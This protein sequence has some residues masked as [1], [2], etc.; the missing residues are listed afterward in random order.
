THAAYEYD[1][2]GRPLRPSG[3]AADPNPFRL[4]TKYHDRDTQRLYH[5]E[6]YYPP[7]PGR[8]LG[9]DPLRDPGGLHLQAHTG[10][11]P[12]NTINALGMI[13]FVWAG[14]GGG[15]SYSG[16]WSGG[17]S[18]GFSIGL[19]G[20][21]GYYRPGGS[22]GSVGRGYPLEGWSSRDIAHVQQMA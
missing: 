1:P 8:F 17:A 15:F 19:G 2:P 3:P 21:G 5:N 10:N 14:G 4:A 7:E 20:L 6:R 9:L 11:N 13:S 18:G 22:G 16:G 12:A